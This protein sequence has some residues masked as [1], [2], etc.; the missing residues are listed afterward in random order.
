MSGGIIRPTMIKPIT[1]IKR[2]ALATLLCAA[3]WLVAHGAIAQTERLVFSGGPD[4]TTF[5][6]AANGIAALIS[7]SIAA[8]EVYDSASAG[9]VEN[10]R[11]VESGA[12]DFGIARA[13][14]VFLAR[15]GRLTRDNIRYSKVMTV[16]R[17]YGI[18][19][20]LLVRAKTK[21]KDV[22]QLAGK[23]VAVGPP[24]SGAAVAA[25]RYFESLELWHLIRPQFIDATRSMA[26]LAAGRV[27]AAWIFAPVPNA[28][29]VNAA[30][31]T[32]LRLLPLYQAALK[33][34]LGAKHPYYSAAI[35]PAGAYPGMD[36]AVQTIEDAALWVA[37]NQV[38]DS[39]VATA[40]EQVYS[41]EGLEYMHT[42]AYPTA[43]MSSDNALHGVVT[44]L[45][46]GALNYW[47]AQGLNIS[48][49]YPE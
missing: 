18:P 23:K 39:L 9:S 32:R 15:Q 1:R 16:S 5:Q 43:N 10:L 8:I 7:R 28:A 2:H 20:Q 35:I 6:L 30:S 33:G 3:T 47:S 14:D 38:A 29:I 11:R 27:D 25:Q 37:G 40:L 17:V 45:H 46:S 26:A 44:P 4:G 12:A 19:A 13:S 41:G 49:P 31:G 42:L 36:Q 48:A 24:G 34:T 22:A 21:I